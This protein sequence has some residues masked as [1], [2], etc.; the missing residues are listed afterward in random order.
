MYVCIPHAGCSP[1]GPR[2]GSQ[3]LVPWDLTSSSG[4]PECS[5]LQPFFFFIIKY[6]SVTAFYLFRNPIK[7]NRKFLKYAIYV[8]NI[9][10]KIRLKLMIT[11]SKKVKQ[12]L[13]F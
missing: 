1:K 2:F 7:M 8:L 10:V 6:F 9:V 4:L 13:S 11:A 3:H 5:F 12:S